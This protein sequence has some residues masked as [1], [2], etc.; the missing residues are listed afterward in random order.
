MSIRS[1]IWQTKSSKKQQ[2]I[3]CLQ[4]G[5]GVLGKAEL[6]CSW[7]GSSEGHPEIPGKGNCIWAGLSGKIF[8]KR[9]YLVEEKGSENKMI[10]FVTAKQKKPTKIHE[11]ED[12]WEVHAAFG[13]FVSWTKI[14][15]KPWPF[16]LSAQGPYARSRKS[17]EHVH[18][19]ITESENLRVTKSASLK[20]KKEN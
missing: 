11:E 8:F 14:I 6:N 18:W 12:A 3:Y 1:I 9:P 15:L 16:F 10:F 5:P 7:A 20:R 19:R 17:S 13:G 4:H 2:K